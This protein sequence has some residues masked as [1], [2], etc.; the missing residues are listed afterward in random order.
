MN[1]EFER[2][3]I[4]IETIQVDV[5]DRG[6]VT[7]CYLVYDKISKYGIV[8]DPGYNGDEI[9]SEIKRNGVTVEY[10][11]LTHCHGDHIGA[12]EDVQKYTNAKVIIH[13]NDLDGLY[14]DE[15][16][17]SASLG[18]DV[19]NIDKN[20]ILTVSNDNVFECGDMELEVIHT[21]GHTSGCICIFE[22][23]ANVLFTG[24]TIFMDCYGRTDL[25][26]G[27]FDQMQASIAKLFK[28]FKNIEIY[29]GHDEYGNIEGAKKRINLLLAI[30]SRK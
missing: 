7:N 15:K 14:D 26:S 24:D 12:L 30:K 3:G 13:E 23:T 22:R 6:H 19:Q 4:I 20:C 2:N 29:P 11:I 9:I 8:I 16:N 5:A 27:S 18:V 10:I 17:H 21:P 1:F 28:R 25:K